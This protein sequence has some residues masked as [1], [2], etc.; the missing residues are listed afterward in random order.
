MKNII[1]GCILLGLFVA[2]RRLSTRYDCE[3]GDCLNTSAIEGGLCADCRNYYAIWGT[4]YYQPV[5]A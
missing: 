5:G 4:E 3:V 2:W 1:T